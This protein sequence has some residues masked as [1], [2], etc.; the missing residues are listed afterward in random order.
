MSGSRMAPQ[1]DLQP[2]TIRDHAIQ[3]GAD[4]RTLKVYQVNP[5]GNHRAPNWNMIEPLLESFNTYLE[6]TQDLQTTNSSD[7]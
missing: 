1:L 7:K 4:T 2:P 6:K 5:L 3:L